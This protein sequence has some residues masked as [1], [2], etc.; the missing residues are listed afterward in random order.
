[1][2]QSQNNIYRSLAQMFLPDELLNFFEVV[3][4]REELTGKEIMNGYPEKILHISLDEKVFKPSEDYK[5]NGFT[6]EKVVKDFPIRDRQS[7]LHVRRR[8]WISPEGHNEVMDYG[9][10]LGASGTQLSREFAFFLK[11]IDRQ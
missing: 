5:P 9:E 6:E 10:L 8:R 2:E 4:F 7:I 3:G 1:M 11:G